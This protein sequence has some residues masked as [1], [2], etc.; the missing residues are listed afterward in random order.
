MKRK[1]RPRLFLCSGL[2]A[3]AALITGVTLG[4]YVQ[5]WQSDPNLAGAKAFYFTSDLLA[6]DAKTYSLYSWGDGITIKLQNFEDTKRYTASDIIYEVTA[7]SGTVEDVNHGKIA[8]KAAAAANSVIIHPESGAAT[9]TV[10][11]SSTSPYKKT[12]SATF[13]LKE[14][15]NPRFQI[16][17]SSGDPTAELIIKGANTKQTFQLSWDPE[18][19]VPDRTNPLITFD[20][21]GVNTGTITI[22]ASGSCSILLFKKDPFKNYKMNEQNI[23]KDSSPI[24]LGGSN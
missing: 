5:K 1:L 9:V 14:T 8:G 15:A 24:A 3:A 2:F 22:N 11:A 10:T 20:S 21:S 12:L 23:V 16:A 6:E 18:Q 19:Y 13:T 7:T 17:D 4:R